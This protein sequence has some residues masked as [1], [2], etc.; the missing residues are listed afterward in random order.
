MKILVSGAT[1]YIGSNLVKA[2]AALEYQ[3]YAITRKE[4]GIKLP[5]I[6]YIQ[7]D[8]TYSSLVNALGDQKIDVIINLATHFCVYHTKEDLDKLIDANLRLGLHL[9]EFSSE[10]G[11]GLFVTAST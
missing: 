9:L 3:V 2:L 6:N 1:G 5:G 7:Y 4:P 11:A 8:G 10:F